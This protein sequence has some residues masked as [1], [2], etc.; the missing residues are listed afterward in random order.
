MES[1]TR[2][3]L[4]RPAAPK[5]AVQHHETGHGDVHG[6]AAL[7]DDAVPYSSVVI[8]AQADERAAKARFSVRVRQLLGDGEAVHDQNLRC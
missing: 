2:S 4:I 7:L 5:Q 8:V 6:V 1:V 3:R